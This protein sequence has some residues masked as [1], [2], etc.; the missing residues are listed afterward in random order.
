M[1]NL[2]TLIVLFFGKIGMN[3]NRI[4]DVIFLSFPLHSIFNEFNISFVWEM[5]AFVLLFLLC[6]IPFAK[7]VILVGTWTWSLILAFPHAAVYSTMYWIVV[8]VFGIFV[9]SYIIQFVSVALMAFFG[10]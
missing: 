10:R 4:L 3:I 5:L 6:F 8:V 9:L 7:V 2:N 1:Y